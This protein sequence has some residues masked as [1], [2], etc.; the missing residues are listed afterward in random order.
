MWAHSHLRCNNRQTRR[1][2]QSSCLLLV[3]S[4]NPQPSLSSPACSGFRPARSLRTQSL[5]HTDVRMDYSALG[6]AQELLLMWLS[7]RTQ[8]FAV[9][10]KLPIGAHAV[11]IGSGAVEDET[12][13]GSR[14]EE[15]SAAVGRHCSQYATV[16]PRDVVQGWEVQKPVHCVDVA[17]EMLDDRLTALESYR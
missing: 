7:C 1:R 16:E 3:N 13:C 8:D 11:A 5:P 10:Q 2:L 15:Q 6:P 9:G 4:H 12:Q 14:C 17:A